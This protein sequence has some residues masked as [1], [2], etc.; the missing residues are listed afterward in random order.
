M[1]GGAPASLARAVRDAIASVDSNVPAIPRPMMEIVR[2]H[3]F[4]WRIGSVVLA[5][6][7]VVALS[8]AA[9]GLYGLVAYN[10]AQRRREM[11]IR[12][13]LGA[14]A[15]Q[16]RRLVIGEGV[17]LTGV[18][19]ALGIVLSLGVARLL[20]SQLYGVGPVDPATLAVVPLLF[21][22]VAVLASAMPAARAAAL[23]PREVLVE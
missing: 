15:G 8:L 12:M 19:L 7:G 17:R 5:A 16:L 4:Q 14:T 6:F 9:L 2:E 22:A 10:V 3:D 11:G 1:E 23:Q 18:G 13:A 21:A 20:A